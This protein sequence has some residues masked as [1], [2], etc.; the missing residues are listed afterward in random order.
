MSEKNDGKIEFIIGNGN[1]KKVVRKYDN[2]RLSASM[3]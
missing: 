3:L 1:F 2:D